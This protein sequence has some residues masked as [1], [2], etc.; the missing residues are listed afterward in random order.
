VTASSTEA[1]IG[2]EVHAQLRTASK[3]FC[4]CSTRFGD[5]PNTNV[6][7]VCLGLPGALPVVNHEA[8]EMALRAALALGCTVHERSVFARKNY[9]YPDLP[10][11][12]QISQYE[13][14]LATNG[15]LD[16]GDHPVRVMRVHMEE[17]AGKSLHLGGRDASLVDFN[18]C[19]V[20]LIE[21]VGEPD[22]RTPREAAE[23]LRTLRAV[24]MYVGVCDG[25][26]E[27]GSLRCDANVSIR[28]RGSPG[29]GTKVEVKNMNSARHLERAL[30]HEIERQG[31]LLSA[32]GRVAQETRLYREATGETASMRSKEEAHD[33]R[34]FPDPDLPPL[35]VAP[36]RVAAERASL[37]ELPA[38]RRARFV[39]MGLTE[40]DAGVLTAHPAVA[41]FFEA[42][43][44][45]HG[46]AKKVANFVQNE[47][48]RV[49]DLGGLEARIP[50]TPE[51]LAVLLSLVDAGTISGTIAK[52]VFAE[53]GSNGRDPREIIRA[54][55]LTQLSDP[56]VLE[57][58]ARRVV[59]A[60][61]KEREQF[62]GGKTK[63]LGFF[64]G[65]VMSETEGRA[66][67]RRV[68]EILR[69]ILAEDCPA[70]PRPS[71][72]DS[73]RREP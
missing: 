23:Y 9:F 26:M 44:I 60:H 62:R 70:P 50:V 18:R 39:A 16:L 71:R 45:V 31:A 13:R 27:E 63:V 12:Y 28:P 35:V 4:G 66:N 5:P 24:L 3:L 52:E 61:P 51:G 40:Y 21:I 37:P 46:D 14:P 48:L 72:P 32:G 2:L 43:A 6:C 30:R 34:Y 22:L 8:V 38:A 67:P 10:K 19:G 33:Y 59:A 65:R 64:V 41:S 42:A 7:P 53:V 1:V 29:L 36:D 69:R 15:S 55:G 25:H 17:D 47:V 56:A 57:E 58:A 49:A 73:G 11:G 20:P 68:N 54:R